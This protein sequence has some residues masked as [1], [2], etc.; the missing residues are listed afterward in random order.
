MD[1]KS[2]FAQLQSGAIMH[3]CSHPSGHL[4]LTPELIQVCIGS[5][6]SILNGVLGIRGVPQHLIGLFVQRGKAA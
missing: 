4:G 3:N 1:V 2:P 6:Q 5:Q